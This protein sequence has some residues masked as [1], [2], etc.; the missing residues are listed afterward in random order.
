VK[1]AS[2]RS[3]AFCAAGGSHHRVLLVV[4]VL[5]LQKVNLAI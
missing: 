3:H 1:A 2:P 5:A 4:K